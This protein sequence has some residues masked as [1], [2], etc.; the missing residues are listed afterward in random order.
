MARKKE[1]TKDN[2]SNPNGS[3]Q[4]SFD[5]RQKLCW[6]LYI[7]PKSK[8]FANAYQ[9]AQIAGYEESYAAVITTRPWFEEKVRKLN[10]VSKAERNLDKA[11]D[12]KQEDEYG[13]IMPDIARLV[14]DV[15]KTV[16]TTLGK[17]E[18]YS[19]KV[20]QELSNPDGNLKTIVINRNYAGDDKPN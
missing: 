8:T 12:Y 20:E 19:T 6:E 11:L 4:Y 16:V 13:N 1:L 14:I 9:S 17:N 18:G 7:D 10:M 15:S 2:P 5:P 3:N